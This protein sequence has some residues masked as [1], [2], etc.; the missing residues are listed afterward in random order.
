MEDPFAPKKSVS[1]KEISPLA[2]L[3]ISK[4]MP[5]TFWFL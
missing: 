5:Q 1:Q 3:A 2:Y 4:Y